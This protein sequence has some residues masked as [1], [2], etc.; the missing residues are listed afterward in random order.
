MSVNI[1]G[2]ILL[3]AIIIITIEGLNRKTIKSLPV[4]FKNTLKI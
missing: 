3:T 4:A 1:L 2:V